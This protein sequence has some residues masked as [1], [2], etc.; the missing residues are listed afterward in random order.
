M[1]RNLTVELDW[2]FYINPNEVPNRAGIY[3]ILAGQLNSENQGLT[4]TYELLDI[5]QTGDG[6]LR[7]SGHD[8][9]PCWIRKKPSNKII[10]YKFSSMPSSKYDETDRRIVECCLRSNTQ[11][12][13]GME[14]NQGYSRQDTVNITNVGKFLPLEETY[15]CP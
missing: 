12:P 13:C 10:L 14:C 7:L 15:S 5:G 9:E 2:E 3:M 11:P 8:R 6:E 4:N 1:V